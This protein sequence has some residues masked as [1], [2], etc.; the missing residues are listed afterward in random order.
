MA[1]LGTA[2]R[3]APRSRIGERVARLAR[4]D[5]AEPATALF[6]I[7]LALLALGLLVQLSHAATTVPPEAFASELRGLLGLRLLG[8]HVLL[9]AWRFGPEGI[10]PLVPALAL[11]TLV[12][13]LL[14]YVPFFRQEA[15]GSAR[16]IRLPGIPV[17][18]QPSEVAR[19][20]V[21][22]WVA[23]RCARLA[24]RVQL[25]WRGFVP[26]FAFGLVLFTL[27]LG[28][29]DLGGALLF[30][31]GLVSTMW[32]GGARPAHVAGSLAVVGCGG[33]LYAVSSLAYVRQRLSVWRG[34]SGNEQVEG[35]LQAI[36]SGDWLGVGYA[37][38]AWRNSGLQYMQTDYVY[39]LV[40]EELGLA[41]LL[42]VLILILAFVWYSFR[43][44]ISIHDRYRALVAF[45][46][47]S[48]VALQAM[49]HLQVVTKLAPPKGMNL[50][51]LSAGGSSLVA[52]ALAVGL[53]L[54]AAR[55]PPGALERA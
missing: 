46:L 21:V 48:T 35:T 33:M 50:P 45:G 55:V 6:C 28:Q 5:P 25:L 32:V 36:A 16:W 54:G 44:V 27:I 38:G 40:G 3:A 31:L 17:T 2:V 30:L 49:L 29:P 41:G 26:T 8:L 11:G 10:R 12:A 34:E 37:H 24:G 9:A 7:T 15:N 13:L 14:C 18:L 43:L 47:L 1:T 53:A 20:V 4:L 39:S 51:F 22:L 23:D 42:V 19:V 52:S